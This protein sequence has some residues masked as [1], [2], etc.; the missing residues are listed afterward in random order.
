[1]LDSQNR[2]EAWRACFCLRPIDHTYTRQTREADVS[3][4][5][6]P[7][8]SALLR[9]FAISLLRP[10]A[11]PNHS[12]NGCNTGN[13]A[14]DQFLTSKSNHRGNVRDMENSAKDQ[15]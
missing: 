1:M 12:G 15:L 2:F 9:V 3:C 13:S 10:E 11:M 4:D 6:I 5:P 7:G 8:P 14:K